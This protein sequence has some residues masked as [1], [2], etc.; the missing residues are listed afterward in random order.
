V[1]PP[2][3]NPFSELGLDPRAEL[4]DD[5]VRAAWRRLATATHPDR[6]DGGDPAAFAA[7]AAAYTT[8]RTR[9]GRGEARADLLATRRP[10]LGR[11]WPR[12]AWRPQTAMP[13]PRLVERIRHG[14]PARLAMRLAAAAAVS[15]VSVAGAG[16]QPAS[17][18]IIAGAVTWLVLTSR[19]D[20]APPRW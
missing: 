19:A 6:T 11:R 15:A 20:L 2:G 1:T 8:L 9:T 18:G 14:R 13:S 5:D 16:W 3:E 4:S 17:L 12:A 10:V 7:A